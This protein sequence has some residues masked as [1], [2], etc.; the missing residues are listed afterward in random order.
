VAN[1]YWVGGTATWDG[2][3]LLKWSTTSG[4]LGGS[5]VPTTSDTVFFDANSG[6]N[7]VTIGAGV[8]TC[9]TLTMTGFTGTIAFGTNKITIAGTGT[10]FTGATTYSVTGTPV[11]DCTNS[12]SSALSLSPAVVTEANSISFNITA[13]SGTFSLGSSQAVKSLNFTGYTGNM[14]AGAR[15]IYGNLTLSTGMSITASTS[16][17]TFAA[18]SGTQTITSNAKT[19]DFPVTINGVGGTVQLVDALTMGS[20][21][22]LT[23]T[24]GTF[25]SNDKNVTVGAFNYTNSNTKTLNLGTS[26]ITIQSGTNLLGFVGS[27]SGTTYTSIAN[28]TI[29]FTTTATSTFSGG[30]GATVGNQF[31]T[32]TMSGLGGTL[33]LGPS[34]GATVAR[35][36]T[37]NNT[38]QPCTITNSCTTGFTVTNF[39]LSGTAGKLITFNSNTVGTAR[40]ISQASGTI[41]A[42]YLNVQDS[43]ATSGAKWYANSSNDLG[44]NT[45]WNI[46]NNSFLAVF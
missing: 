31:G 33:Y 15:T 21:R 2:T 42:L 30:A 18:T 32:V 37:L 4:G 40:T 13:S 8:A 46:F 6:A 41:N 5:A 16:V 7:T 35:C 39:N 29:I 10:I 43:T 20:T 11:I 45:G 26:T 28:S 22:T 14:L 1:R 38:V 27:N 25:N 23:L 19:M 12:G 44:N 3:A 36:T 9:S 17:T 24:N 34:T